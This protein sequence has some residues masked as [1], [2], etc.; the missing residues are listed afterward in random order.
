MN[1]LAGGKRGEPRHGLCFAGRSARCNA[2]SAA[3]LTFPA[4]HPDLARVDRSRCARRCVRRSGSPAARA[5][6][7][8]SLAACVG[9][10][11]RSV[12]FVAF[13]SRIAHRFGRLEI[14]RTC[15]SEPSGAASIFNSPRVTA[16]ARAALA[17]SAVPVT[18]GLDEVRDALTMKRG[19]MGRQ[20]SAGALSE[21]LS[22]IASAALAASAV[23]VNHG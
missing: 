5:F 2:D 17:A 7:S 20:Q 19:G 9:G 23:A 6:F 8:Y 3:H 12:H 4:G 16:M 1:C 15:H 18:N 11:S 14:P 10:R 21:G 22:E 13:A